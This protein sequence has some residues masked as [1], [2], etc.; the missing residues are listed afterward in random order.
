MAQPF[1]KN[2]ELTVEGYIQSGVQKFGKRKL[3]SFSRYTV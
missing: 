3:K 2:G 1:I